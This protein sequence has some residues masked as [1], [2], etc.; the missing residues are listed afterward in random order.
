MPTEIR[1]IFSPATI[2]V[3]ARHKRAAGRRRRTSCDR[4]GGRDRS[5]GR[6]AVGGERRPAGACG[7]FQS[8]A[9]LDPGGHR[10]LPPSDRRR[11]DRR[12]PSWRAAGRLRGRRRAGG[13]R[14]P[15]PQRIAGGHA[16]EARPALRPQASSGD[17]AR[18]GH[19]ATIS[20]VPFLHVRCKHG[21]VSAFFG[22]AHAV[23]RSA[24]VRGSAWVKS[25]PPS[26]CP[27]EHKSLLVAG[28]P[29]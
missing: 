28:W 25:P 1:S 3:N 8:S 19:Q 16:L 23:V 24:G 15:G 27:A 10:R 9:S 4:G 20:A 14:R 2:A 5:G 21:A 12:P 26:R 22:V 29:G 13:L 17:G 7:R 11:P 6:A 18:R